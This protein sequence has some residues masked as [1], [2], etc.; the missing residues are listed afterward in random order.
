MA[1]KAALEVNGVTIAV[2]PTSL[3]RVYP[4]SHQSLARKIIDSGGTLLT[5]YPF[6]SVAYKLNFI[7]R[8]RLVSGLAEVLLITEAAVNSGSLHTAR[9][10]L[11]QGKTVMAVP[12]NIT[13]ANSGGC[14]NLIKSGAI[15]VTNI[16]DI[17]FALNIKLKAP[18]TRRVFHGSVQEKMILELIAQGIAEQEE[19]A[20][21]SR[22]DSPSVNSALT[23][24]EIGGY[25]RAQGGGTW[26]AT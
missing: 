4:A 11:E 3:D 5:E 10:A 2:L 13:S 12:G 9:F 20:V 22:L 19:L 25:I 14:N 15:P 16:E 6:G 18:Q 17:F 1:H 26:A 23:M 24:L 21:R 8:N 7:A